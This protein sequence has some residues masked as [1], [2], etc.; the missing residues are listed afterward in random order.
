MFTIYCLFTILLIPIHQVYSWDLALTVG[1]QLELYTNGTKSDVSD[2]TLKELTALAYDAVHN[3]LFFADKYND[4]ASIFSYHLEKKKFH[5]LVKRKKSD[6]IQGIAFDPITGLLFWTD[7][8]ERSIMYKSIITG[9]KSDPYGSV[10]LKTDKEIPRAIVVDSCRGYLYWTNTYTDN[11]TIERMRFDGSDRKVIIHD[12]LFKPI[13]ITI[14]Q[15]ENRL[16]WADDRSGI[17]YSIDSSDL[18]GKLRKTLYKDIYHK[19]NDLTVSKDNVYWTD[20]GYKAVWKYPKASNPWDNAELEKVASYHDS[21]PFG[22]VAN[23]NIDDQMSDVEEC[24]ELV[25]LSKNKTAVN[26][27]FK[28]LTRNEGLFCLHGVKTEGILSCICTPG[29]TGERC[30]VSVCQNFCFH[31]DCSVSSEGKPLCNCMLGYK[32]QRCEI[33]MCHG[34]CLN[35]GRCNYNDERKAASCACAKD[36]EGERCEI[37]KVA[38]LQ[39][40]C[41]CT[42][43]HSIANSVPKLNLNQATEFVE[44]CAT[45]WDAIRDPIIM[46][47]GTICGILCLVCAVLITKILHLKKRPRIKK[48]IIMNKNVTP[49][50][51]RPDQ[52]EITIEN[53]C[54]MNICETPCFETPIIRPNLLNKKPG[55]EEK[56]NLIAN[57]EH[58][59]DL[60]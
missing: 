39:D 16:Y 42:E 25:N 19:P 9:S 49:L 29:Y 11:A 51:A 8:S 28:E 53:C 57:M 33:D 50:T 38:L 47:L 5:P 54:N 17:D 15:R 26:D 52:C 22:I 45:E 6:N 18:D 40:S 56:K 7:S 43:H 34:Y 21:D 3:I 36:Y 58:Q 14:D 46:A 30:E 44:N 27:S 35:N 10:L 55:K 4:N 31:G 13:S 32:G 60:Y 1:D 23:Y 59:D 12:D 24:K 37:R 41:N 20:W 2:V 48:R